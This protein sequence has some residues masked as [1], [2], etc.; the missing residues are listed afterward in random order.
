MD[1]ATT[2]LPIGLR[3][4][5]TVIADGTGVASTG[6]EKSLKALGPSCLLATSP[7]LNPGLAKAA[8]RVCSAT[9]FGCPDALTGSAIARAKMEPL[10]VVN[11]NGILASNNTS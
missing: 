5:R 6:V 3:V 2:S 11:P 4:K 10:Y 7:N 1:A 8:N 9:E